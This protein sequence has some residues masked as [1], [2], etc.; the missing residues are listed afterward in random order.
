MHASDIPLPYI[1]RTADYYRTLGY[2]APYQWAQFD[3]VPFAPL[4]RPLAHSTVALITTAAPYAQGKGDQGPGA[5]YNAAAKFYDVYAKS[6]A[7][8][9]DLRISHVAIDRDHT[10]AE[11]LGSYFPLAAL[12]AAETAGRIGRVARRF[13]GLP[14][15]R[16]IKTT[17]RVDA[18]ALLAH[19]REDAVE[20][21]VFIPNCPVCHQSVSLAARMLE[22]AGITTVIMGCAR[23]IVEHV[24]VP[25]FLFSDFPLGNA[26]GRPLDPASQMQT[27]GMALDLLEDAEAPRTTR[28]SPLVWQGAA[29]WKD[30][31]S[32]AAKLTVEDIARR[33]QEFD[34]AKSTA[35]TLRSPTSRA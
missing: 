9:P 1:K 35:K 8:L 5:L 23:D 13:Y 29:H 4:K 12:K 24:G 7:T 20:V 2:G 33:K 25:R 17:T 22:E 34:A 14:T 3:T 19:C 28:R 11:D 21:A 6:T 15:N 10:T 31:Y 18:P 26:A 16:S 32:N 30:D 27:L